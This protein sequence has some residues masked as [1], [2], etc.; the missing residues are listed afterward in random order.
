[1]VMVMCKRSLAILVRRVPVLED[2]L[3]ELVVV[4]ASSPLHTILKHPLGRLDCSLSSAVAMGEVCST[5]PVCDVPVFHPFLEDATHHLRPSVCCDV[6]RYVPIGTE[7]SHDCYQVLAVKLALWGRHD[8]VPTRESVS[9][10]KE[11]VA[12][13]REVVRHYHLD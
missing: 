7:V 8:C 5:W 12:M 10:H 4:H 11:I 9:N 6:L 3:H 1:M 13:Q 2:G